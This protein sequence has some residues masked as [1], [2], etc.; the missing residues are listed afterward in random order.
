MIISRRLVHRSKLPNPTLFESD[1]PLDDLDNLKDSLPVDEEAERKREMDRAIKRFQ[2]MTKE[3]DKGVAGAYLGLSEL[4]EEDA[5]FEG[6][7]EYDEP[8]R[9]LDLAQKTKETA[10]TDEEVQEGDSQVAEVGKTDRVRGK[11]VMR[12]PAN[13]EDRA[14]EAFFDDEDWQA[15][16]GEPE[17]GKGMGKWK[18][19]GNGANMGIKV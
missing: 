12:D 2:L 5:L 1:S 6:V 3:V 15:D 4:E 17:R 16:V 14:L 10:R 9:P 13:R 11:K 8:P 7:E 18:T 19:V